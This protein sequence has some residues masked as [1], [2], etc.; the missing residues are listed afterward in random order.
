MSF[1]LLHFLLPP[2]IWRMLSIYIFHKLFSLQHE[3][4]LPNEVIYFFFLCVYDVFDSKQNLRLP[5]YVYLEG[6]FLH[7]SF[8]WGEAHQCLTFL[9]ICLKRMNFYVERRG[10]GSWLSEFLF[11]PIEYTLLRDF[12]THTFRFIIF[13]VYI[14]SLFE[15]EGTSHSRAHDHTW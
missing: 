15:L 3:K 8:S 11:S 7:S 1:F 6:V 2:L 14:N 12:F 13:L 5:R 4:A 9:L 10:G